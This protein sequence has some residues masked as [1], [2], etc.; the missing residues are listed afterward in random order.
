M[1]DRNRQIIELKKLTAGEFA[2]QVGI[3]P[4]AVSHLL[5]GRNNPSL[6]V[7]Q[8]ILNAFRDISP[9]WFLFGTGAIT[10]G[11]ELPVKSVPKEPT[12][13]EDV[14]PEPEFEEPTSEIADL[15]PSESKKA[16]TN[17]VVTQKCES[18]ELKKII[19]FYTDG[20]F[21]IR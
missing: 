8:K 1:N 7:V 11:G 16:E 9:D 19:V 2:K 21:E 12:L 20:T 10:R 15:T 5:A 6:D 13:F 17:T 4:G 3:Q 14:E 18:R